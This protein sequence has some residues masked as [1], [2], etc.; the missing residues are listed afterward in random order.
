MVKDFLVRKERGELKLD[1]YNRKLAR[2]LQPVRIKI[3]LVD[4]GCM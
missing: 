4:V 3:I 1:A 2:G